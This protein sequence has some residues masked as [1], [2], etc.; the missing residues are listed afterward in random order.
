LQGVYNRRVAR[1]QLA[2]AKQTRELQEHWPP[3]LLEERFQPQREQA[4]DQMKEMTF[5]ER[6]AALGKKLEMQQ[7]RDLMRRERDRQR[8]ASQGLPLRRPVPMVLEMKA[9][10]PP[11]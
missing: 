11:G 3:E 2:W 1:L 10:R 4:L 5:K 8:A 9:A 7:K 6:L